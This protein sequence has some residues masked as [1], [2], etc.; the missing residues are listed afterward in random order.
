MSMSGPTTGSVSIGSFQAMQFSKNG[1]TLQIL[2]L[3][4]SQSI[5]DGS[6]KAGQTVIRYNAT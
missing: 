1:Q 5:P 2:A 3:T 4:L 6:A